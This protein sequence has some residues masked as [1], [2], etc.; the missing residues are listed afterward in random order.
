MNEDMDLQF[1]KAKEL[2]SNIKATIHKSGKLGFNSNAERKL[3]LSEDKFILI[4]PTEEFEKDA[5][6]FLIVSVDDSEYAFSVSKAGQ[7]YYANTKALYDHLEVNY[8][9]QKI[10]YDIREVTYKGEKIFKL[11]PR[12][13]ERTK[14][15]EEI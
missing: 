8:I 6:L 5:S 3:R 12:F 10:I 7:Y 2:D 1:F 11:K 14:E 9:D 15:T 13:I 4:A